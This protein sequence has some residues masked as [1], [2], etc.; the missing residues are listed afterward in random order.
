V[1]L[2]TQ[3][4]E[5]QTAMLELGPCIHIPSAFL[6]SHCVPYYRATRSGHRLGARDARKCLSRRRQDAQGAQVT[7]GQSGKERGTSTRMPVRSP[8]TRLLVGGAWRGGAPTARRARDADAV[9]HGAARTR[10]SDQSE[11]ARGC[12][13][14]A[15]DQEAR[16]RRGG[17]R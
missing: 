16:A 13:C 9:R 2:K 8:L 5:M 11:E 7:H 4:K 17:A 3:Q 15:R 14:G 6:F 12:R 1:S 10:R